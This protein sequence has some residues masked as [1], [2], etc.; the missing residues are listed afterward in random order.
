MQ[1]N[2]FSQVSL[3]GIGIRGSHGDRVNIPISQ[4]PFANDN[5]CNIHRRMVTA[6]TIFCLD[7]Q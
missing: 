3:S 6:E 2:F 1:A 4:S 5:K 7:R